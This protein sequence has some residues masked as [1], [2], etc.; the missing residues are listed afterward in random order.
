MKSVVCCLVL[1]LLFFVS[2]SEAKTCGPITCDCPKNRDPVCGV[3]GKSY[4]NA[5]IANCYMVKNK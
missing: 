3:S 1:A 4:Q 2:I 5:C